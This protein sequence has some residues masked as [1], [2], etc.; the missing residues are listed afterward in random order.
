MIFNLLCLFLTIRKTQRLYKQEQ[1][2]LND[3]D[4]VKGKKK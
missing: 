2:A 4:N 1:V 3:N